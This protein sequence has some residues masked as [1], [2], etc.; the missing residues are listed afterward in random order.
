MHKSTRRTPVHSRALAPSFAPAFTLVELLVVIGIIALLI[1][2]LLPV[3]G[4]VRRQAAAV[5]CEAALREI[6]NCFQMYAQEN[7]GN[8]VWAGTDETSQETPPPAPTSANYAKMGW[9]IDIPSNGE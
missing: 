1:S 7:K 3:L 9:V 8:L 2:I 6:G 4:S 5:K